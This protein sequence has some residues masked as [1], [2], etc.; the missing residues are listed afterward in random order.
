MQTWFLVHNAKP[1]RL[2]LH[3]MSW[4]I[5]KGLGLHAAVLDIC[6]SVNKA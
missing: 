2:V 5:C 4:I 6:V 1:F 3:A